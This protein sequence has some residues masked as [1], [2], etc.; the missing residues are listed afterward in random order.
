MRHISTSTVQ[1]RLRESGLHGR[2]AAKKPLLRK[3]NKKKRIAWAKKHREWKLDQWKSV[4][5][6]DERRNIPQP[7][8]CSLSCLSVTRIYEPS[9]TDSWGCRTEYSPLAAAE[10]WTEV[11]NV[12]LP[13]TP[14]EQRNVFVLDF[15]PCLN[16]D[17]ALQDLLRQ[18]YHR[19]A[20]R[21]ETG[22][23]DRGCNGA[24]DFSQD[25]TTCQKSLQNWL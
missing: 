14:E 8:L 11:L 15:P 20:A 4:L 23:D 16:F 21:M 3:N 13:R 10:L 1:R 25:I 9:Q 7:A 17:V 22:E 5:W 19:V 6:S 18:E 12:V 24:E 2:I